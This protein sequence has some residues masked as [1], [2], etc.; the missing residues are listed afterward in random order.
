[1]KR[2]RSHRLQ[3]QPLLLLPHVDVGRGGLLP[4][5]SRQQSPSKLVILCIRDEWQMLSPKPLVHIP[6]HVPD[7][8]PA[9]SL[10]NHI[11]R[12]LSKRSF[13]FQSVPFQTNHSII[14]GAFL[15]IIASETW[16]PL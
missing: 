4:F 6:F 5:D 8:H 7:G 15:L 13:P 1:M 9:C 14:D 3:V 2:A 10:L 11:S 16:P 12:L